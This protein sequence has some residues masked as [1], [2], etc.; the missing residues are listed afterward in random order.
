MEK[1]GKN[2]LPDYCF[3]GIEDTFEYIA[4]ELGNLKLAYLHIVDHSGMGA[5]AVG[6]SIK[7]RI[8]TTF[9]GTIIAGGGM[10]KTK[11]EDLLN[12]GIAELVFFGR[13]FISN[14]DLV[15]RLKHDTPLSKANSKTF[16]TT[17]EKGYTDYPVSEESLKEKV[18]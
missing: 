18:Q 8:T 12:S 11:A 7:Q 10:D 3:Q 14:P 9:R 6:D 13:P 1:N 15:Y 4:K 2:K 17:G 16:Y 5:P